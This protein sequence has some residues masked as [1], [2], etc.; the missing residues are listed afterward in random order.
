[1]QLEVLINVR[2]KKKVSEFPETAR[3]QIKRFGA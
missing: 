2:G 1:M 3:I